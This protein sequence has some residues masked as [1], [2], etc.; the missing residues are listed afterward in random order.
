MPVGSTW[1]KSRSACCAANVWIAGSTI[2]TA[3]SAKSP[4]GRSN[5][6]PP[7][8]ASNGCSQ[9]TRPAPKWAGP[10]LSRPT[11]PIL[12]R[13]KS[14]NHWAE[15]LAPDDRSG[16]AD[17]PG[18][19]LEAAADA[20]GD[21]IDHSVLEHQH[22]R[23]AAASKVGRRQHA[24]PRR[25]YQMGDA[26]CR[27]EQARALHH[28]R[29]H[30]LANQRRRFVLFAQAGVTIKHGQCDKGPALMADGAEVSIGNEIERFLAT[31][32]GMHPPPD[33]G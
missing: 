14:H 25:R 27:A 2:P 4:H 23:A 6:M 28:G 33:V 5:E 11:G 1:S 29:R 3:S 31:V 13:P 30:Q 7:A 21:E 16:T 32:V 22:Q 10:I 24:G 15:V 18:Q 19:L 20:I 12:S 17:Q 26:K 9:S 8:L